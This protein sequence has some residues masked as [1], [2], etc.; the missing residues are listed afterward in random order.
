MYSNNLNG[1]YWHGNITS[2]RASIYHIEGY[3]R[4]LIVIPNVKIS[5][6]VVHPKMEVD[7]L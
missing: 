1:T 6:D 4:K 2:N 5:Q 7:R 3:E